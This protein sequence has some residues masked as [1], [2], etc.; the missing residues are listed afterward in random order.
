MTASS[1]V[2]GRVPLGTWQQLVLVDLDTRPRDRTI[3]LTVT[4]EPGAS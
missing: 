2:D 4:G 3:I 1:H